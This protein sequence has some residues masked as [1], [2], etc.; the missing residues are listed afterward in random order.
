MESLIKYFVAARQLIRKC[1]ELPE[2][3]GKTAAISKKAGMG[4]QTTSNQFNSNSKT[5]ITDLRLLKAASE[6]LGIKFSEII[7]PDK[8]YELEEMLGAG[9]DYEKLH[10]EHIK[11]KDE[12]LDLTRKYFK[13][14]AELKKAKRQAKGEGE[15]E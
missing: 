6:E 15:G 2:N 5:G 7:P 3:K 12:F 9:R 10:D 14:E 8:L 13:L 1:L 11:L 4:H